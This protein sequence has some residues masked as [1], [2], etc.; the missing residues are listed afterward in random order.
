MTRSSLRYRSSL[1]GQITLA[2]LSVICPANFAH[3]RSGK[4]KGTQKQCMAAATMEGGYCVES[5]N[6][7]IKAFSCPADFYQCSGIDW[8]SEAQ[9][10][11]LFDF[12]NPEGDPPHPYLQVESDSV[13]SSLNSVKDGRLSLRQ[14]GIDCGK[15]KGIQNWSLK[16]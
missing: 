5:E 12:V 2:L 16:R 13:G 9:G 6:G 10:T 3:A 11:L 4:P 14:K 15:D 7:F 8:K 1:A